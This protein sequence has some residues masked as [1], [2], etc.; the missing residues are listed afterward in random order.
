MPAGKKN[1]VMKS[2]RTLPTTGGGPK[3][4]GCFLFGLILSVFLWGCAVT[5]TKKLRVEDIA[6][7]FEAGTIISSKLGTPVTMAQLLADLTSCRIIYVGEKHTSMAD[8]EIQL[9]II[10]AVFKENPNLA[11]GMEMFDHTYQAVL[12][13]WSS[14]KLEE[15][16]FLR[17]VHWYANWRFD[18]T[19]YR[20]IL[21]FI[22]ENHIRLVALNIPGHIPSKIRVG[23]LEN[24]SDED[25]AHLPKNIDTSSDAHREYVQNVFEDHSHH[26]RGDV[27]FEDFYAAQTVWE[28]I[29]A[30]TI[31]ENLD[32]GK[33]VVLAGNGHIQ[34]KYGIPNRA[35]KLTGAPFRTIYLAPVGSEVER[36]IADYIWVTE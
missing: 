15:A 16:D 13:L 24:L 9:Q 1:Q 5:A 30:E 2:N 8:H 11:V 23:G 17:K 31:A 29:M 10:Q 22:K 20:D 3:W 25:K 18:Y 35:Y 7:P 26:F 28:D 32:S 21:N 33:M 36:D 34:F 4:T 6:M 27:R 19:L 14:G 12:E